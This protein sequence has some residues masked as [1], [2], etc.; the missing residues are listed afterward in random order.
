MISAREQVIHQAK[1]LINSRPLYLDTETTGIDR[2]SEIV[3][4]AIV[5]HIGEVIYQSLVKPTSSI[6]YQA[7]RIHGIDNEMVNRSLGWPEV[8]QE[9]HALL[10][11]RLVCIF[12]SDFDVRLMQQTHHRY[13]MLWQLGEDTNFH[14]IM[15]LYAQF[16]GQWDSRRSTYRYQSLDSARK[17]CKLTIP[18][19][20]RAA[21]DTL[22]ARAVL[23]YIASQ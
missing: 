15:K 2:N 3:E 18:N 20:H 7:T 21:D 19:S 14:C 17:Q 22:L 10:S 5:N 9:V 4:I 13:H 11:N 16:Y 8:W 1:S 6:P 23:H 12:N